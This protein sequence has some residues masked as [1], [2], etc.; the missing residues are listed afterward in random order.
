MKYIE[1]IYNA[2]TG[3]TS[4]RD[5]TEV[6]VA[7]MKANELKAAELTKQ[8]EL[9]AAEKAAL[10]ARLGITAEEANLLLG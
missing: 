9:K 5:Y 3:E 8:Q 1:R 2:S 4:E 6:E 10:L 7:E